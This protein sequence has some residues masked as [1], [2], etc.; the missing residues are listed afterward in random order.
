MPEHR[1]GGLCGWVA[2]STLLGLSDDVQP[3]RTPA[4][5]A[6]SCSC[7]FAVS[8]SAGTTTR[9]APGQQQLTPAKTDQSNGLARASRNPHG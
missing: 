5:A 8:L 2:D 1:C 7:A 9:A 4:L 3:V 6:C